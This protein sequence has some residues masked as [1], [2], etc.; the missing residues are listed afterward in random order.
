[1]FNERDVRGF[2]SNG[3]QNELDLE[4]AMVL[5]RKLKLMAKEDPE[6]KLLRKELRSVIKEYESK[7]WSD[8][9]SITDEQVRQSDAAEFIAE[10]ERSFYE[11][12]KN[13]IRK[14]LKEIGLTQQGLG[15]I[16]GHGKSYISEL[17]NG[18]SPFTMRD[19][20]IIHRLF[21][22]ELKALVPT[23][24][25]HDDK[26]KLKSSISKL[27]NPNLKLRSEDLVSSY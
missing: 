6:L 15:F 17:V 22:I 11:N 16:L 23:F 8:S 12:R 27:E 1:M 4:R 13:I 5:D 18:V 7:H 14:K 20:V 19:L 21:N 2:I 9:E 10:I 26:V 3:I 25:P 24:I